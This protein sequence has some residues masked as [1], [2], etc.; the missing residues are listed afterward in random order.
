[1]QFIDRGWLLHFHVKV[2]TILQGSK[3]RKTYQ[4]YKS[5]VILTYIHIYMSIGTEL[6][7]ITQ[8]VEVE[9]FHRE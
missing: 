2:F 6:K 4:T 5:L 3:G 7:C 8:G 9:G 1:M